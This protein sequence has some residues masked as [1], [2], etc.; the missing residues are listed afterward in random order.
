[1][2]ILRDFPYNTAFFTIGINNDPCDMILRIR[3]F[4][5]FIKNLEVYFQVNPGFVIFF[6][7]SE[8]PIFWAKG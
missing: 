3:N 8:S 4:G 6:R 2:V 1:M 5:K 7:V